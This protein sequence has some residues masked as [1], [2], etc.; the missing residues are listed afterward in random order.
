MRQLILL[1]VLLFSL[2]HISAQQDPILSHVF[3]DKVKI[4]SAFAGSEGDICVGIINRQQ[5]LGFEGAPKTTAFNANAPI[6]FLGVNSGV[7]ISLMDDRLGFEKNFRGSLQYAYFHNLGTGTLRLGIQGG[8]Y[9][10][11]YDGTWITPESSADTDPAIPAEKDNSMVF[12]LAFGMAYTVG[13]LFVGLSATHLT[14]PKFK[15]TNTEQSHLKRHYY[16]MAGYNIQLSGSNLDLKPNILIKSDAAS[17]Q[18]TINMI[19]LYNKKF[20]GGV[21]YRT[22][23]AIDIMAGIELFNGIKI[24]YAYGLNFSKLSNTNDGSHEIML[25]Y[26]FNIGFDKAP[27]KYRSVRFL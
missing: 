16:L 27:Q 25:G 18:I 10:I 6:N 17:A 20:W 21:S 1:F 8:I 2:T 4:N 5:W 9:N 3:F 7:G 22:T 11:A 15:F 14:Q 12:D 24:G 23:D 19:A 26:C 13:D